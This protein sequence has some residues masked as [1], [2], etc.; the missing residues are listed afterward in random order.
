VIRKLSVPL[1]CALAVLAGPLRAQT[2]DADFLAARDAFQKGQ[3]AQLDALVPQLQGHVL[4]PWAEY[5]QLRGRLAEQPRE[6]VRQYLERYAGQLPANRLR[7]DWLRQLARAG[8]WDEFRQELPALVDPDT[9]IRCLALQSRVPGRDANLA[10][11]ARAAWLTGGELPEACNA[12]ADQLI[13]A[14]VFT[15]NDLWA[16]LR[17]GFAA[18]NVT[19]AKSVAAL[20]PASRRPDPKQ[21]DAATKNPQRYLEARNL[22]LDSRAR[23][24]VALFAIG[25]VASNTPPGAAELWHKLGTRLPAEDKAHG[26]GLVATAAARRHMPEALAWFD[27]ASDAPLE[28]A[29]LAWA[30]RAAL[31]AGDWQRLLEWSDRMDAEERDRPAWRYWRARAMAAVGRSF[32]SEALMSVLAREQN[33]HGQLAAEE[34]GIAVPLQNYKPREGEI[35]AVERMPGIQRALAWYRL[36]LRYE[37]NLE[38]IWSIRGLEDTLLIAAAEVARREGWYERA[39]ATAD[40]SV[41]LVNQELRYPAPYPELLRASARE[42]DVDEALI[43]GLVR[44]E[45]RFVPTARSSVGASGL[46]Q[47]MPATARWIAGRLGLKEWRHAV[48]DA[49]D[50]NVNF[51]TYYLKEMLVRLDGSPVLASAAYN[52][53]PSRAQAWRGER[54][55][56]GAIYIDTIPFNETRDYV[57]K[58]MANANQYA[59]QFGHSLTQLKARIGSIAPRGTAASAMR[60]P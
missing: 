51:G 10:R 47:I 37:G 23:R 34:L 2:P 44:Q 52:A 8:A 19:V 42:M 31:R 29:Q 7:A 27:M 57:R 17:L 60:D 54:T 21:V 46:M 24:E 16:R 25:R 39:I 56:E 18:G 48:E 12:A 35:G 43:Y 9:E 11:D 30:A 55:L 3:A 53:G 41:Q 6:A 28:T 40:R 50:A 26:W 20:L 5:W 33:F 36:G 32:E 49:I 38:W 4:A 14:G 13:K 15:E 58:V 22:Q 59:R 45:S 1:L